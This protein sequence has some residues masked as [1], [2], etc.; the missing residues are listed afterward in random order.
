MADTTL[1]DRNGLTEAEFLAAYQPK[2]YP[3]P[4]LT[5][6]VCVF[7][8]TSEGGLQLLLVRRGGHPCLG[9][10]A[11]PGGFVNPNETA[12]AAAE[13]E[14][15][16]ETEVEGLS[17]EPVALYSTPGRDARGW[18]VSYAFVSVADAG[19]IARAAD[20]ADAATWFDVVATEAGGRVTLRLTSGDQVLISSFVPAAGAISGRERATEVEGEGLAFDHAEIVADAWLMV[21]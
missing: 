6:D 19:V 13:R 14:L 11:T 3:H 18:T 8:R 4:S 9:M 16:E 12:D 20:D 2:D 1:R 17:L 5:A 21:R 10:W 7:R 15:A